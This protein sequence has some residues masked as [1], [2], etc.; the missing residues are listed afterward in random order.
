MQL[1]VQ[2]TSKKIDIHFGIFNQVLHNKKGEFGIEKNGKYDIFRLENG[3]PI[4]SA[5][6]I[7]WKTPWFSLTGDAD[8]SGWIENNAII[9]NLW[10]CMSMICFISGSLPL[11]IIT[12]KTLIG[13]QD[14]VYRMM[15]QQ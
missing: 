9:N 12:I 5:P 11:I 2:C 6:K 15:I 13:I 4:V 1:P 7:V 8:V 14:S 10:I 3:T